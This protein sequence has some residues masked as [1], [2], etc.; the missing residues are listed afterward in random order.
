MA[1]A[2]AAAAIDV[3]P[4]T[5]VL[6]RWTGD[7]CRMSSALPSAIRP[8]GSISRTSSTR[9]R[10]ASACASAPPIGPAPMMATS[11]IRRGLSYSRIMVVLVAGG[12]KGVG[13]A[14]ARAFADRNDRVVIG[15]RTTP[16]SLATDRL[17]LVKADVR[18]P[19]DAQALVDEA[20]TRFGGLDVL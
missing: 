19:R 10:S 11:D 12:S 3:A 7:D 2:P 15:A 8:S 14:I 9:L 17:H 6:N 20:V 4:V 16:A 1:P 18:K 5:R 13:L